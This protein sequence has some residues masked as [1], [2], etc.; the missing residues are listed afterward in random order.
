MFEVACDWNYAT[1]GISAESA[2]I[3]RTRR[4][5]KFI[6]D[7]SAFLPAPALTR[8]LHGAQTRIT[9]SELLDERA[10]NSRVNTA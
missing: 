7:E 8:R 4:A 3:F 6:F 10:Q 1:A 9:S 2:F 5:R